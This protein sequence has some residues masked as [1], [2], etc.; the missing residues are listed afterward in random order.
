MKN[1]KVVLNRIDGLIS[2]SRFLREELITLRQDILKEGSVTTP[3]STQVEAQPVTQTATPPPL[4]KVTVAAQTPIDQPIKAVKTKTKVKPKKVRAPKKSFGERFPGLEKLVGEKLIPFIGILLFVIGVGFFVSYAI[5]QN[6]ISESGRAGI[7]VLCGGLLIGVAHKLSKGYKVFSSI[8]LGGGI[9]TLYFTVAYAFHEYA[10]FSQTAAFIMMVGVTGFTI[11]SSLF[12]DRKEIAILGLLGGFLTPFLVSTGSGNYTALFTYLL[13]LN[14]GMIVLGYFKNWKVLNILAFFFTTLLFGT[15]MTTEAL[16]DQLPLGGAFGFGTAFFLQ[17]FLQTILYNVT[18]GVKFKAI[19]YI[20]LLMNSFAYFSAGLFILNAHSEGIY[21]GLFTGVLASVHFVFAFVLYKKK[22]LDINL[23]YTLLG[24]VLTF[25]T[26]AAPIQLEGNSITL[27]WAAEA[28]LL[29]WLGQ[30]SGIKL[31]KSGSLIVTI[32]MLS[33]LGMDWFIQFGTTFAVVETGE[34]VPL[35][36]NKL[37]LTTLVGLASLIS[38]NLLL[39]KE[40]A[41]DSLEIFSLKLMRFEHLKAILPFI[42]ALF[43]Y[44]GGFLELK[45]QLITRSDAY[46]WNALMLS[47]YNLAFAAGLLGYSLRFNN[48][49]MRGVALIVGAMTVLVYGAT[50][51]LDVIHLRDAFITNTGTFGAFASHYFTVG[52]VA[53]IIALTLRTVKL[54]TWNA[55]AKNIILWVSGFLTLYFLSAELDHTM[56]LAFA[57]ETGDYTSIHKALANSQKA[58][59]QVLWGS[60]AFLIIALGLKRKQL[61]LRIFG[62]TLLGI[63]LIKIFAIDVWEMGQLGRIIAFTSLGLLIL[64]ISFLY[65]RIFK[66]LFE[67]TATTETS[68]NASTNT[69]EL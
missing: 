13:V 6:W 62:L 31:L 63:T 41:K 4:P 19:E 49:L 50:V 37:F 57:S 30:K 44:L 1:S 54:S 2:Q 33:S 34:V 66:L 7:G 24:L 64:V 52:L 20:M 28:V 23:I 61:Q 27:F 42:T 46:A 10:L 15:W 36:I 17:F 60:F 45:F 11:L 26:L 22:Q 9:A 48:R 21:S 18:K 40:D 3:Q 38:Y 67:D 43:I 69:P 32:A 35:F 55:V 25:L 16:E 12:Y 5:D 68:D 47:L 59:Y 56:V 39:R 53:L 14:T 8:L 51:Q 65:Q 58:G 29:L